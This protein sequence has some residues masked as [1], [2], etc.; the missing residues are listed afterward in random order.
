MIAIQKMDGQYRPVVLCDF[1]GIVIDDALAAITISST[2][3]DGKTAQAFHV[4]KGKCDESMSEKIGAM[5]GSEELAVHLLELLKNTMRG[6]DRQTLQA[7]LEA[8]NDE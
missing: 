3:P 7:M 4:H 2:A 5:L 6:S 8:T 1:C